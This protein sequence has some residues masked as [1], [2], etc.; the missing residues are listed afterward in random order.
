[1]VIYSPATGSAAERS[2]FSIGPPSI[3]SPPGRILEAVHPS[4]VSRIVGRPLGIVVLR[5]KSNR[6]GDLV[7]LVD[8]ILAALAT[9]E[10]GAVMEIGG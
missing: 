2:T 5:A 4:P 8:Q 9:L 6:L 7:P 10:P 1:M 3:R